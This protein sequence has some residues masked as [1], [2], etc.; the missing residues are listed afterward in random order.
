MGAKEA[1]ATT[2]A[3]IEIALTRRSGSLQR[4]IGTPQHADRHGND[5]LALVP[6][7]EGSYGPPYDGSVRVQQILPL[8]PTS[9]WPHGCVLR[10][11]A[12]GGGAGCTPRPVQGVHAAGDDSFT[13][14]DV[15]RPC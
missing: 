13:A 3:A 12:A 2:V 9:A 10:G 8:A 15:S 11:V 4:R 6:T 7:G 1:S 5:Q 14:R